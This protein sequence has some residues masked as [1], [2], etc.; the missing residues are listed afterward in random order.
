MMLL[1][2]SLFTVLA[3]AVD[4][5]KQGQNI[6]IVIHFLLAILCTRGHFLASR[7]RLELDGALRDGKLLARMW[8]FYLFLR[9]LDNIRRRTLL[10]PQDRIVE[11][12]PTVALDPAWDSL[13]QLSVHEGGVQFVV[14]E[15]LL[16]LHDLKRVIIIS[17]HFYGIKECE[18]TIIITVSV[19]S[20][21]KY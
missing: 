2:K 3:V 1:R 18:A 14:D 4:F 13:V 15:A 9:Q 5:V 21:G 17:S 16:F 19:W 6:L 8:V 12:I 20:I 11:Q 7:L 10:L